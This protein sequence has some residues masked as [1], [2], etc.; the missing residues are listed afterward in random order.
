MVSIT[1]CDIW[2]LLILLV[3]EISF[4]QAEL[5]TQHLEEAAKLASESE[6]EA[7]IAS[8][9]KEQEPV[10]QVEDSSL[11]YNISDM[12]F[13]HLT[14]TIKCLFLTGSN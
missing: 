8:P 6:K 10:S 2:C 4:L 3:N 13:I 7:S 9:L 11:R 12:C 1:T 14:N 5:E